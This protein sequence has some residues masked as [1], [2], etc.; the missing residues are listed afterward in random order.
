MKYYSHKWFLHTTG[1]L[2]YH[3]PQKN[4]QRP[5][6]FSKAIPKATP[7]FYW[8]FIIA[9]CGP[10][11]PRNSANR[12]NLTP[13]AIKAK[14]TTL[15][16]NVAKLDCYKFKGQTMVPQHAKRSYKVF[17]RPSGYPF[18]KWQLQNQKSVPR[19]KNFI[20]QKITKNAKRLIG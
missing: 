10:F 20:W 12:R 5:R 17:W 16:P 13:N 7:Q 4:F 15:R 19:D 18:E 14:K 9:L 6:K 8:N 2:R 3:G 11:W 1:F